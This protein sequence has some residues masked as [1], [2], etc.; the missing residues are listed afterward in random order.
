MSTAVKTVEH[1]REGGFFLQGC[2]CLNCYER[3]RGVID[4]CISRTVDPYT[5]NP[6]IPEADKQRILL[7]LKTGMVVDASLFTRMMAESSLD[8]CLPTLHSMIAKGKPED[9]KWVDYWTL[10]AECAAFKNYKFGLKLFYV[11]VDFCPAVADK[12]VAN[13]YTQLDVHR[14]LSARVVQ[15]AFIRATSNPY[16]LCG[17]RRLEREFAQFEEELCK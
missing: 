11:V 2:K 7:S 12:M 17:I 4:E 1:G 8:V 14:N 10:V 6:K 9:E 15:K 16:H 13:M 3:E 5:P